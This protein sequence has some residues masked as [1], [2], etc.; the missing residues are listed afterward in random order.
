M[1]ASF[2]ARLVDS[3]R[4][5]AALHALAALLLVGLT[6]W[7]AAGHLA[8]DTDIEKLL[9]SNLPWRQNEIGARQSAFPQNADLLAIVIDERRRR[10][11]R[12]RGAAP[13][14]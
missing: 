13:R 5:H 9:P 10:S 12:H 11:G 2:I 4:R 3:S 14:R 7:Y 1:I 6:G 8:I